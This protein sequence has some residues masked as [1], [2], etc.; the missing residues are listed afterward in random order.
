MYNT[1]GKVQQNFLN[2]SMEAEQTL[3]FDIFKK[4]DDRLKTRS[5]T[6]ARQLPKGSGIVGYRLVILL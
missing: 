6:A 4:D 2:R 5:V 1:K 3:I